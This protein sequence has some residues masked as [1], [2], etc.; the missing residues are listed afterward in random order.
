MSL[1][2]FFQIVD[3]IAASLWYRSPVSMTIVDGKGII[4]SAFPSVESALGILA[5]LRQMYSSDPKD[6]LFNRACGTY[7]RHVD[8][9]GKQKW[10]IAEKNSFNRLLSNPPGLTG[11]DMP[12]TTKEVLDMFL[13]GAGLMHSRGKD[14]SD[15]QR[16]RR[17]LET[18][19]REKLVMAFHSGMKYLFG[20]ALTVYPVIKQDFVHWINTCGL[21]A[22]NSI[23]IVRLLQGGVS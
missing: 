10:V 20:H 19:P 8:H 3:Q 22:P 23:D 21:T 16:L 4:R 7:L 1:A 2:H 9:Q 11:A 18:C 14:S 15:Q 17:M 6:D 12:C 5:L 13:Y